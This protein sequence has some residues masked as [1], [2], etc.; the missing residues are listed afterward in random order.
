[1]YHIHGYNSVVDTNQ[2]MCQRRNEIKMFHIHCFFYII[3][4]DKNSQYLH[5][6][7]GHFFF[8]LSLKKNVCKLSVATCYW[9]TTGSLLAEMSRNKLNEIVSQPGFFDLIEFL[10]CKP[11]NKI[12]HKTRSSAPKSDE[13]YKWTK[14]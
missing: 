3:I 8:S 4:F 11:I 2:W 5:P 6:L 9:S 10:K 13:I 12:K 14:F 7:T 1:M